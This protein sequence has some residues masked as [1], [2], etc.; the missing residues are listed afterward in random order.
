VL[1]TNV[2]PNQLADKKGVSAGMVILRV[3]NQKTATLEQYRM[4][5]QRQSL[6][7]GILMLIGSPEQNH[8]VVFQREDGER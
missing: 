6:K 7:R 5:M 1:I 8:F 4:V 2:V 3:D